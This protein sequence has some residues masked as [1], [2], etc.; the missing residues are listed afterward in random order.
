MLNTVLF[1]YLIFLNKTEMILLFLTVRKIKFS[2]NVGL[3][4]WDYF[5]LI[6]PG[7]IFVF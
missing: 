4:V 7:Y 6:K 1:I 5:S 2:D 3:M